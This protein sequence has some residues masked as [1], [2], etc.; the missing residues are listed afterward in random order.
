GW[1]N[2]VLGNHDRHR[3]AS[4]VGREQARVA[5][6]LLLTLRGTPTC[7]YGDEIGMENVPIPPEKVQDPP[8]VNQ[9]EIAHIIGRDPVR[10]PMQWDASPNAGF[11]DPDV[12]PWLPLAPD[13][14]A[15]NVA[16]QEQDPTSMLSL[17]RRLIELRRAHPALHGGAYRSLA[18]GSG[19]EDVFAFER[20]DGNERFLVVLNF[21][22]VHHRIDLRQA[23][24]AERATIL[25][26]TE[27]NR[28]GS[29]VLEE[30]ELAPNEGVLAR[31]DS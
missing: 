8:A 7:Y 2:W 4:R 11:C 5:Q 27:C 25:L 10:T 30:F 22:G 28:E 13:Y 19:H 24:H 16:A 15:R 6:M 14:R 29:V 9:P 21:G 26:N 12:D 31:I 1:P 20:S 17:F 3:V 18:C 23:L